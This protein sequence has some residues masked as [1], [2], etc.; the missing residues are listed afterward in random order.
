MGGADY[1]TFFCR[2]CNL[3][4]D[5]YAVKRLLDIP[6]PNYYWQA[7]CRCGKIL[8][9]HIVDKLTDP[10]VYNSPSLR[11]Q[12][13]E[14]WRDLVQPGDPH[15]KTL[16]TKAQKDLEEAQ[17]KSELKAKADIK[18]RDNIFKYLKKTTYVDSALKRTVE[19]I[20][21]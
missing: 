21:E 3:E 14:N 2:T 8:W 20:Y 19:K 16:Y 1:I 4:R 5:Y 6:T 17:E 12:R 13:Y 11:K 7:K 10:Y 9:R 18:K 15:F